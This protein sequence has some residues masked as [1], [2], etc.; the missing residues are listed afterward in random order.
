MLDSYFAQKLD[1][2]AIETLID[3]LIADGVVQEAGGALSY[4]K[5]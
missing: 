1:A 2:K 5:G 3:A 4:P